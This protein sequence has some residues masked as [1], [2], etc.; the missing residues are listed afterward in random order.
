MKNNELTFDLAIIGATPA[1]IASAI[2]AARKRL[3]VVLISSNDQL[4]GILT[5]GCLLYTSDA[6]D[7]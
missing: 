5:N 1:G 7:E 6:A 2:T 4:G 3:K